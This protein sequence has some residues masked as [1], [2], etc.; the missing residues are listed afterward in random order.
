MKDI[1]A[2]TTARKKGKSLLKLEK[3]Y[4]VLD[5][6]TTGLDPDKCEIIEIA[7]LRVQNDAIINTFSS[8]V[9]PNKEI[10]EFIVSLTGITNE[11]V[12][13]AP[14]ID[15]V[16]PQLLEFIGNDIILGHN[17]NFDINFIYDEKIKVDGMPF[18]NDYIDTMRLAR[19]A[20]PE[21]KHHRLSDLT[22]CFAI[23]VEK[24]HRAKEDCIATFK[25]YLEIKKILIDS[26]IDLVALNKAAK[27]KD[28]TAVDARIDTENPLYGKVCVFTGK[29]ERMTR[30]EAMQN[31]V[32]VGGINAD[33]VTKKTNFLVLGNND[34]CSTIK[35]GKST[36]QKKAEALVLEGQD[37]HVISENVFYDMIAE[38]QKQERVL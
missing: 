34:F 28:F 18:D 21:L 14:T 29:L 25:C 13:N 8:F 2:Y 11:M 5:L 4:V 32:N 31:V 20:L 26:K 7:A 36:K 1:T 15:V 6:E 19:K 27:A 16:L 12:S 30:A 38:I 24:Q 37:I 9:K 22:K 10:D 23:S 3:S 35:D 33:G 17:I